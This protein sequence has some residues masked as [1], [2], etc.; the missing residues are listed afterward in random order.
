MLRFFRWL[1]V[2]ASALWLSA[3]ASLSGPRDVELPLSRLEAGLGKRFPVDQKVLEM[4]RIRLSTPQL[5][6]L[7]A[8]ERILIKLN[9]AVST[10]LTREPWLGDLAL[11]GRL[12]I[13]AAQNAIVLRDARVERLEVAGMDGQRGQLLNRVADFVAD[14]LLDNAVLHRFEADELRRLGTQY[15]PTSILPTADGLKIHFEPQP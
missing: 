5:S 12:A 11:S 10:P 3:C 2:L 14:Q 13:D 4:F 8:E 7:P 15:K 1:A 9:T 6:T